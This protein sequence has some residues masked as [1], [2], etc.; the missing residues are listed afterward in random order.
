MEDFF[1]LLWPFQN[2]WILLSNISVQKI[3]WLN[4]NQVKKQ[5]NVYIVPIWKRNMDNKSFVFWPNPS[6]KICFTFDEKSFLYELEHFCEKRYVLMSLIFFLDLSALS[7]STQASLSHCHTKSNRLSLKYTLHS[8]K[9][10]VFWKDHKNSKKKS[11]T[12]FDITE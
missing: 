5:P 4:W 7:K 6:W 3:E 1:N 8:I 10:Q 2:I 12:C 9:V 11:P